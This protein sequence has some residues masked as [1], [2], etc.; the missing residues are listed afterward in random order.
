MFEFFRNDRLD[1]SNYFDALLDQPD[2]TFNKNQ[3]GASSGG[4]LA[5]NRAFYFITYEGLRQTIGQTQAV[6]VPDANARNGFINGVNVG[7]HPAMVPVLQLYPLPTR[8]TGAQAAQ[9]IGRTDVTND[10][11]GHEHYFVRR[12]DY[13]LT[14]SSNLF[15]R[16]TLD[17]AS[18]FEPNSGSAIPLWNSN[19]D[20]QNHYVTAE[21]RQALNPKT[22]NSVRFG[23]TRTQEEATRTNL[24]NGALK[25]FPERQSGS[26]NP[27]SGVTGVGGNQSCSTCSTGSITLRP[28][29]GSSSPRLTA[30]PRSTRMP[31]RSRSAGPPRADAARREADVLSPFEAP[32]PG[33]GDGKIEHH[34]GIQQRLDAA[35]PYRPEPRA[36]DD[37]VGRNR[38][39]ATI[40]AAC[41]TKRPAISSGPA[42]ISR[43]PV[44]AGRESS[45]RGGAPTRPAID[46]STSKIF[47]TPC[48]VSSNPATRR[49][50]R[51]RAAPDLRRA[52]A[53][54]AGPCPSAARHRDSTRRA[55]PPRSTER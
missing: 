37:Q 14:S 34:G 38:L 42:T 30:A 5:A 24:D 52:A 11:P 1:A 21:L 16:Y 18:V 25:F 4:P 10:I 20:S 17:R 48:S 32:R 46:G 29:R 31:V 43:T 23:T 28:T 47:R 44:T 12:I 9:E 51:A 3:F 15:V 7:V 27:G 22:A 6:T 8:Q 45:A 19:D 40:Q 33:A 13:N 55:L 36:C 39:A 35:V 26:V 53:R 41:L 50:R 2:P 54:L 49:R